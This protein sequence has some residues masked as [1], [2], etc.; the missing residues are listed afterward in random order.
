MEA[1]LFGTGTIVTWIVVG[2]LAGT[3]AGRLVTREKAGFGLLSNV[4]LGCAGAMVGGILFGLLNILPALDKVS[5]SLRDIVA[6]FTGSLILLVIL[7]A[8]NRWKS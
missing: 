3:L 6:A 8:W 2:L 4:A 1:D 7:W 5:V